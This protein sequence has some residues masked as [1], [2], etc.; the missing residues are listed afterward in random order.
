[1]ESRAWKVH[2]RD[3]VGAVQP[4]KDQAQAPDMIGLN[5]RG[6]A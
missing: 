2:V 1:M 5:P 3:D 4:S 6:I